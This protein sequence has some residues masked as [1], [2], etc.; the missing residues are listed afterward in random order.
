[1]IIFLY[2]E[3]SYSRLKKKA[4]I[5][6]EYRAKRGNLNIEEF[7]AEI[8]WPIA[9]EVFLK[10]RSLFGG[11]K[12][13]VINEPDFD[14]LSK[15]EAKRFRALLKEFVDDKENVVLFSSASAAD[16]P[17]FFLKK[18]VI[19]D[20]YELPK[21]QKISDFIK[22]EAEERGLVLSVETAREIADAFGSDTWMIA[23]ELDQLALSGKADFKMKGKN[24]NYFSLSNVLKSGR[25]IGEKL[26]AL[27]LLISVLKEEPARIFNGLPYGRYFSEEPG[28]WY[29]KLADY[30]AMVKS[31]KLDYEEVLLDLAL[32]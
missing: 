22:K 14:A 28:K 13:A 27:E 5:V 20:K 18:P 25:G 32:S 31:G 24:L 9:A 8:D 10:N 3:D 6:A 19:S 11:V 15:E 12:L 26:N 30:D 2:G 21:G 1:M 29:E 23:T 16:A 17:A 7:G 4:L